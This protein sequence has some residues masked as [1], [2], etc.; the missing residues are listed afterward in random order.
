MTFDAIISM[1]KNL[2]RYLT[3]L[4]HVRTVLSVSAHSKIPT[5]DISVAITEIETA[6][7]WSRRALRERELSVR[8][9]D[10]DDISDADPEVLLKTTMD[11]LDSC[12]NP[13][14]EEYKSGSSGR[15][16]RNAILQTYNHLEVGRQRIRMQLELH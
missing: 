15:W 8:D 13:L 2:S 5:R 12:V 11:F 14:Q 4:R 7:L 1:R 10:P 16:Y 9:F 6:L 3:T